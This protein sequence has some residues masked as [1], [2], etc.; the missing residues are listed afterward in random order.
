MLVVGWWWCQLFTNSIDEKRVRTAQHIKQRWSVIPQQ[1]RNDPKQWASKLLMIKMLE[2]CQHFAFQPQ[3]FEATQN[4][5]QYLKSPSKIL[6]H[7]RAEGNIHYEQVI[8][9]A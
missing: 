6:F 2:S 1:L 3:W 7:K 9:G 5:G 4:E 8:E